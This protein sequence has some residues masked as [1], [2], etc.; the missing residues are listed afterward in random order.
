M[1]NTA[2]LLNISADELLAQAE[3]QPQVPD[4]ATV[5]M[6][7]PEEVRQVLE[8]TGPQALAIPVP[9][10]QPQA[11]RGRPRFTDPRNPE[12]IQAIAKR[13]RSVNVAHAG[14]WLNLSKKEGVRH[15]KYLK[16]LGNPIDAE[17]VADEDGGEHL[18]IR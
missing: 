18:Y 3:S 6:A 2:E 16:S 8:N 14:D 5:I 7:S 12:Q 4:N 1:S 13:A 11:R 10:P 9:Q 15:A 17:I